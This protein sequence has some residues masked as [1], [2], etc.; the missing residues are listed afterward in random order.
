MQL[1]INYLL[2]ALTIKGISIPLVSTQDIKKLLGSLKLHK[3]RDIF[4]ITAEHVRLT[5]PVLLDVLI[6]LANGVIAK[7][8]RPDCLNIENVCPVLKKLED[9]KEPRQLSQDNH[10]CHSGQKC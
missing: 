7:G 3:A 5:S 2:Q 10:D 4:G 9:C 6:H 8:V 1:Q